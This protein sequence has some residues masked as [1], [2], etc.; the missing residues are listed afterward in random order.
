MSDAAYVTVADDIVQ[1]R[2][3][4]LGGC[5]LALLAARL[6]YD[7][8]PIREDAPIMKVF[9]AGHRIEEEVLSRFPTVRGRQQETRLEITGK[10][11]VVGHIDGIDDFDNSIVEVKSQNQEEWD[12]FEKHHWDA[13]FFPKYKWQASAYMHS[14]PTVFRTHRTLKLIRALRDENGEW[15]GETRISHVDMP[16]YTISDIRER[17]LRVEAVAATGTLVAECTPSFPCPYF[18]L[19]EEIDRELIDDDTIEVLAREYGSAMAEEVVAKGKKAN[20]RKALRAAL[21]GD[22]YRTNTGVRITFYEQNDP[23][24][25]DKELLEG[26][27][28]IHNRNYDEFVKRG[29]SERMRIT[30]PREDDIDNAS[31]ADN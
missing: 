13:G 2:A 18:Y 26:F 15:T 31:S 1:Y 5:D 22:K 11:V 12:R 6:G 3:S 23:P 21:D 16:F 30:L 19:H 28:T 29:R 9:A 14:L 4:A 7:V 24:R 20:A 8:V 25:L 10:I 27:L 17:I